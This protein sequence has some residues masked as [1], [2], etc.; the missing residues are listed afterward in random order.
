MHMHMYMSMAMA[1]TVMGIGSVTYN[2][3]KHTF[4]L[5]SYILVCINLLV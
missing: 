2:V 1:I 3:Y 5:W 4:V